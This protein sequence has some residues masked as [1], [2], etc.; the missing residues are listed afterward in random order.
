[1]KLIYER[2]RD[3]PLI[4]KTATYNHDGWVVGGSAQY[5]CGLT[6]KVR[7]W[8]VIVPPNEWAKLCK[9]FP[10]KSVTNTFGGIKLL[11]NGVEVDL[12]PEELGLYFINTSGIIA[13]SPYWKKVVCSTNNSD[14]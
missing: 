5:L 14:D 10:Y 12:W 2:L 6:S 3:I 13:V 7:D 9:T 8:D 4:V 1:M 11:E